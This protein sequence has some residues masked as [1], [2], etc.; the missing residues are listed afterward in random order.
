MHGQIG[1]PSARGKRR[2]CPHATRDGTGQTG[3]AKVRRLYCRRP[4]A[5]DLSP[6]VP[7]VADYAVDIFGDD[8][9]IHYWA[10]PWIRRHA[11]GEVDATEGDRTPENYAKEHTHLALH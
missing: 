6:A 10:A 5:R 9:P 1:T 2:F 3:R 7:R 11:V 8:V 4:S